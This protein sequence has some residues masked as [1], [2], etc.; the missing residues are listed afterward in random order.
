M[1]AWRRAPK[2]SPSVS[3]SER[4]A[5]AAAREQHSD[6]APVDAGSRRGAVAGPEPRGGPRLAAVYR[7]TGSASAA[8]RGAASRKYDGQSRKYDGQGR[9]ERAVRRR[10]ASAGASEGA[11]E[12]ALP[13]H[14]GTSRTVR[15]S[16]GRGGTARFC[17]RR[18]MHQLRGA[19]STR[20]DAMGTAHACGMAIASACL[21]GS[22]GLRD[23]CGTGGAWGALHVSCPIAGDR[24]SL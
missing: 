4:L 9:E 13:K 7:P 8:R 16:R 19:R 21:R 5:S 17:T 10:E 14:A 20:W 22:G 23:L 12:G 18:A 11:S 1:A 6:A 2:I 3:G 24:R 15:G